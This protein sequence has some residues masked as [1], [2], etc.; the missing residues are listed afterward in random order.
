MIIKLGKVISEYSVRNK[1][2]EDI[3]VYS[4]TNDKGFCTNYFSKDVSSKDRTTYKIVPYGY[5]AYNPS[6]INVG[7]VDWQHYEK[8]VIVSPLYVVFYVDE[9]IDQRY[10]LHYLKS[11][12]TLKFIKS[13]SAGSVR[14]NLKLSVLQ[15][16]SINLRTKEEQYKIVN[17]LDKVDLLISL[18]TEKLKKFDELTKSLFI[19]MFGD[20]FTNPMNWNKQ[21]LGAICNKVIRYPTFYGMEY[22]ETGIKVIRIGNILSDGRMDLDDKKY[23]FIDDIVNKDFPE[24]IIEMN[25]IIMAV[26]GDGSAA[27]RIGIIREP[28]LVGA[29]ISPNLIRIKVDCNKLNP[30]YMF[31]YLTGEV[32]QKYLDVYV[33]KTAKKNIAAKDIVKVSIYVP[34]LDLQNRFAEYV[35]SIDKS[36]LAVK[37]SLEELEILK[38]SLMQKYF[39]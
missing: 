39:A 3:P 29:N 20:L 21:P 24:T 37:K 8:K 18:Y 27:K 19:E 25:D 36:K 5:F 7:S 4:V 34:P 10:L 12:I 35:S 9:V 2:D 22:L 16:F 28:Q 23:V 30:I 13:N 11:D 38:K 15:E 32:G 1:A 17:I 26:R 14:D 6:R 33:N 31:Y